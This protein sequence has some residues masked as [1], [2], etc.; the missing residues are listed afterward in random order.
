MREKALVC[1]S[2]G[3]DSALALYEAQQKQDYEIAALLTTITDG[4]ARVSMHGVREELL[5][6]QCESLG[7]P[8]VKVRIAENSSEDD[9][10]TK[11]AE[12][13]ARYRERG[14]KPV[15]FGD[16][17]LEE[18]RNYREENL[19]E[20]GMEAVFP[21]W[22]RDTGELAETF[23]DLGFKAVVTGVDSEF[24]GQGHIG[25]S[26]DRRFL[27]GLP[28]DVDPCGE[29]GEFHSFVYDGPPV[30]ARVAFRKGEIVLREER[31][32]YCDLVLAE[33]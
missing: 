10:R 8:V 30:G 29:N 32:W 24:L 20:A 13:L 2:G 22:G 5:D 1:W 17:S 4:Y 11:I 3:K 12:V 27:A 16:I 21:L 18:V 23:I 28:P 26:F 7:I 14:A 19:S 9:Y 31:F 6:R 33:D 25:R 15:V